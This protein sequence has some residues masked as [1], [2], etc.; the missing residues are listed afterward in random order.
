[1]TEYQGVN[2]GQEAEA[3]IRQQGIDPEYEAMQTATR[4]QY[5]VEI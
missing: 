4:S 5:E 3:E 2:E 1:M